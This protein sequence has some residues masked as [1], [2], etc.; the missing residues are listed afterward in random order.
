MTRKR[1]QR[2][3]KN[4]T[5]P[6][7][8]GWGLNDYP[9]ILKCNSLFKWFS[10]PHFGCPC[11]SDSLMLLWDSKLRP[12]VP[13]RRESAPISL[14]GDGHVPMFHWI[15]HFS[16]FKGRASY[17]KSSSFQIHVFNMFFSQSEPPMNGHFPPLVRWQWKIIENPSIPHHLFKFCHGTSWL[18]YS[19]GQGTRWILWFN[20]AV[21]SCNLKRRFRS[22]PFGRAAATKN[23][24]KIHDFKTLWLN[25]AIN[26]TGKV[27]S[28]WWI[29]D[30]VMQDAVN[31]ETS[32]NHHPGPSPT[33][34]KTIPDY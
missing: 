12:E 22:C 11:S 21:S 33:K 24:R 31:F 32:T 27:S 8:W 19:L 9:M 20:S 30:A 17:S 5:C 14:L 26:R 13:R 28:A 6:T 23:T 1:S 34:W 18:L 25:C 10:G 15:T 29:G 2:V 16:I 3:R 4:F 7:L